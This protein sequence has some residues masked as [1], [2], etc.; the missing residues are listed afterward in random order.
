MTIP[1][2]VGSAG[3]AGRVAS[4]FC[5]LRLH[6]P[7]DS[8]CHANATGKEKTSTREQGKARAHGT[9]AALQSLSIRDGDDFSD[10]SRDLSYY[11][12]FGAKCGKQ[13]FFS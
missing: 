7:A 5:L 9:D 13:C 11:N 10:E 8:L 1:A 4:R 6:W 12:D 3:S 2:A